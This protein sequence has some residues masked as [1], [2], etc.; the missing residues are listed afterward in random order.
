[1]TAP[2]VAQADGT[3]APVRPSNGPCWADDTRSCRLVRSHVRHRSTGPPI[4]LLVLRCQVHEIAFTLYPPGHFPYGR[5]PAIRLG[6][7][8]GPLQSGPDEDRF[9]GTIFEAARDAAR[10]KAWDRSRDGGSER[11]WQTQ[12]RWLAR[13]A[14]WLGVLPGLGAKVREHI[15]AALGVPLLLLREHAARVRQ[16]EG[17]RSRGR[18]AMAALSALSV[19]CPEDRLMHAGHIAGLWGAWARCDRHGVLR[20]PRSQLAASRAPPSA[21]TGPRPVHESETWAS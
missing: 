21:L 17:Y 20:P 6:L 8:G 12:R 9:G 16:S 11:W 14:L 4:P 7:D 18:A 2:Y 19:L 1:M 3:F 13:T 10:G 5:V 15:A